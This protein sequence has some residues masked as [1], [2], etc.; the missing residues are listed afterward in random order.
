MPR[1]FSFVAVSNKEELSAEARRHHTIFGI[2]KKHIKQRAIHL[3]IIVKPLP[4]FTAV[5]SSDNHLVVADSPTKFSQMVAGLL[6]KDFQVSVT[7]SRLSL[8][9]YTLDELMN[10]SQAIDPN[11]DSIESD[12]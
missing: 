1:I 7:D 12:K 2:Q 10:M 8:S 3:D 9:E 5:A 4:A 6:P 11:G